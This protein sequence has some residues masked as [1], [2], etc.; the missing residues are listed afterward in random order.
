MLRGGV[1]LDMENLT[2]NGG[3]AMRF[4][5]IWRLAAAQAGGVTPRRSPLLECIGRGTIKNDEA[6]QA[7]GRASARRGSQQA[8]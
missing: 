1:F 5:T 7:S 2:R 6:Q 3:R 4:D 8:Q